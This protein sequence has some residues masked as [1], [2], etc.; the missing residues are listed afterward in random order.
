MLETLDESRRRVSEAAEAA[1]RHA[2]AGGARLDPLVA[3][4]AEG[5]GDPTAVRDATKN[6]LS[7]E[8][9]LELVLFDT[10]RIAGFVFDSSR[11]PVVAGASRILFQLN[12]WIAREFR[13]KVIFS[14]G[15]Q[16]LLL[17]A[18]GT[19]RGVAQAI[20]QKYHEMSL[21]ALSVTTAHLP[22]GPQDFLSTH[23]TDAGARLGV[24]P[25]SG[26]QALVGRLLDMVR[27]AKAER[28][29][30]SSRIP[31]NAE[32]CVSCR[33]RAAGR[34]P[35]S[36][37]RPDE[38]PRARLCDPCVRRWE[39]GQKRIA[40]VSFVDLVEA[41]SRAGEGD[42]VARGKAR[43]LGFVYGD[44]NAMGSVFDRLSSLAELRFLSLAISHLFTRA[45]ERAESEARKLIP[46]HQEQLPLLSLL[47]GGDEVI[48]IAPASLA[49]KLAAALPGWVEEE[50][51]RSGGLAEMLRRY[52]TERLTLGVGM[53]LCDVAFPVRYQY[54]LAR[55]LMKNAKRL[56]YGASPSAAT[57]SIDFEV[58]T[59]ASPLSER[60]ESARELSTFTEEMDFVRTCR[61]YATEEFSQL[62]NAIGRAR[63]AGLASSQLHLLQ[64]GSFA[65]KRTFL[66]QLCYQIAR[67]PAGERYQKWLTALGVD[68]ADRTALS[69]HFL[70]SL[71]TSPGRFG[72]WVPDAVQLAPFADLP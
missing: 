70:R 14:G 32:R 47:G 30:P 3:A 42:E 49:V 36:R 58:L 33:D 37:F 66:N 24:R 57:S 63:T 45:L 23:I 69:N 55:A 17:A 54:E 28:P 60:L 71:R 59:D 34:I 56:Y 29:P 51:R 6:L 25:V 40:G 4:I 41:V 67:K 61:P 12:E 8:R 50:A 18:A 43:Y 44:A 52:G 68:P 5:K 39:E 31:G 20:E 48:W 21:G 72:T 2:G 64:A 27:R 13:E 15:G 65:G 19:G 1:L 38:D 9:P 53:V 22:A 46:A 35:L 7:D 16:G 10:D 62:L 11:P 26:T